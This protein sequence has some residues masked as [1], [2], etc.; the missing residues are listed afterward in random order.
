MG[1]WG[2]KPYENDDAADFLCG[3]AGRMVGD[4]LKALKAVKR[5]ADSPYRYLTALAAI[6]LLATNCQPK[7]EPGLQGTALAE[8]AFAESLRVLDLIE[9]DQEWVTG[10]ETKPNPWPKQLVEMRRQILNA[11]RRALRN[12]ARVAKMF[13]FKKKRA[14]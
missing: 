13:G 8:G 5:H 9:S 2:L 1:C 10:W 12:E 11:R 14:A 3:I 6:Q 4:I 7:T